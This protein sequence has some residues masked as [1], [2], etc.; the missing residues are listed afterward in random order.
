MLKVGWRYGCALVSIVFGTIVVSLCI[1]LSIET[2]NPYFLL[3]A[4]AVVAGVVRG[5]TA[6]YDRYI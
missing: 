4:L 5:M 6:R 3:A 2:S 1:K